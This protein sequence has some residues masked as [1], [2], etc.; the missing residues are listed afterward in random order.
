MVGSDQL[1]IRFPRR[2]DHEM[3]VG[4][5]VACELIRGEMEDNTRLRTGPR[6]L[7]AMLIEMALERYGD[8]MRGKIAANTERKAASRQR[9]AQ[10]AARSG[11]F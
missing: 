9:M 8:R 2:G 7:A 11:L 10:P 1:F 3:Q 6:T 5:E 4:F